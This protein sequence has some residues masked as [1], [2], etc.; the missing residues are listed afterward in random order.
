MIILADDKFITGGYAGGSTLVKYK[1]DGTP[2]S[3]FGENRNGIVVTDVADQYHLIHIFDIK[4][5]SDGKIVVAGWD[6][7]DLL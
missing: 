4:V 1:P 2:D 7:N 3:S 6:G 5:Q